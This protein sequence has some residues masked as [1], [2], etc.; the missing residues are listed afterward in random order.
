M[1][2]LPQVKNVSNLERPDSFRAPP[3]ASDPVDL[4][5]FF[6]GGIDPIQKNAQSFHPEGEVEDTEER[7]SDLS[8][9]EIRLD[10]INNSLSSIPVAIASEQAP[11]QHETANVQKEQLKKYE[12][13]SETLQ[14]TSSRI[15]SVGSAGAGATVGALGSDPLVAGLVGGG[16]KG[17]TKLL[18]SSMNTISDRLS[19]VESEEKAQKATISN[20]L[21]SGAEKIDSVGNAGAGLAAGLLGSDPII[22]GLVGGAVKLG[23]KGISSQMRNMGGRAEKVEGDG[24]L[25]ILGKKLDFNENTRQ[26]RLERESTPTGLEENPRKAAVQQ[27]RDQA[28]TRSARKMGVKRDKPVIA[29]TVKIAAAAAANNSDTSSDTESIMQQHLGETRTLVEKVSNLESKDESSSV[30]QVSNEESPIGEKIDNISVNVEKYTEGQKDQH[31]MNEQTVEKLQSIDDHQQQSDNTNLQ[32][33]IEKKRTDRLAL[34]AQQETNKKLDALGKPKKEEKSILDKIVDFASGFLARGGLISTIKIGLKGVFSKVIAFIPKLLLG[35]IKKI[36]VVALIVGFIKGI[37]DGLMAGFKAFTSGEGIFKSLFAFVEGFA[38]SIVRF[39]TFG[40]VNIEKLR[41]WTQPV[42]DII[43]GAVHGIIDTIKTVL[44]APFRLI[45]NYFSWLGE[46]YT[47]IWESLSSA[48]TTPFTFIKSAFSSIAEILEEGWEGLQSIIMAPFNAL[49]NA[50]TKLKSAIPNAMSNLP[51]VGKFFGGDDEGIESSDVS[52]SDIKQGVA[53]AVVSVIPKPVMW[54]LKK[55]PAVRR[56]IEGATTK[57]ETPEEPKGSSSPISERVEPEGGFFG[58]RRGVDSSNYTP[59]TT[60]TQAMRDEH[61][62]GLASGSIEDIPSIRS[63]DSGSRG[64]II[65]DTS[66]KDLATQN[67]SQANHQAAAAPI[68]AQNE[69]TQRMQANIMSSSVMN[70]NNNSSNHMHFGKSAR[71]HDYVS[72]AMNN[73][74]DF[75]GH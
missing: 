19:K 49:A 56:F 20:R 55:V 74:L 68:Q 51:F 57:E 47:G 15:D 44:T 64:S 9:I 26:S 53:Q 73:E 54:G 4:S 29:E 65:I 24:Q 32:E 62:R 22:A 1:A 18:S 58:R 17:I 39:F 21:N 2:N 52:S 75:R 5:F 28:K 14:S 71:K 3:G 40:L 6:E 16:I 38:D 60:E 8:G 13:L 12:K 31:A 35:V 70:Q 27:I 45:G 33:A 34:K 23:S 63:I 66:E 7:R 11:I 37:F 36:P 61:R 48:L 59:P 41:E 46:F 10:K 42:F 30:E 72:G 50:F 43:F 25:S 67:F 69:S